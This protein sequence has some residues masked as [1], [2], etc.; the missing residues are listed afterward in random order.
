MAR[1]GQMD[2][3][4]FVGDYTTFLSK[5]KMKKTLRKYNG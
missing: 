3:T 1:T 4:F 2:T 5:I